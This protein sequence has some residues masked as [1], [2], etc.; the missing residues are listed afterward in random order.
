MSENMN[1]SIVTQNLLFFPIKFYAHQC[2]Q[3]QITL[4]SKILHCS[5][6]HYIRHDRE[7]FTQNVLYLELCAT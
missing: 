1:K 6:E 7:S 4:K 5:H 3:L 2:F